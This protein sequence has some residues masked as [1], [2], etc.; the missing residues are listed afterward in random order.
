MMLE[1]F[2]RS[3]SQSCTAF[4]KKKTDLLSVEYSNYIRKDVLNY[5]DQYP[6]R[7]SS[8]K[9]KKGSPNQRA[10]VSSA[11][12]IKRKVPSPPDYNAGVKTRERPQTSKS[13]LCR[14]GPI[15]KCGTKPC[16]EFI[17]SAA[18]L[19]LTLPKAKTPAV[20]PMVSAGTGRSSDFHQ[21]TAESS[22]KK[23]SLLESSVV[24]LGSGYSKE[25]E[26]HEVFTFENPIGTQ[27]NTI[28]LSDV[29]TNFGPVSY[30]NAPACIL[31]INTYSIIKEYVPPWK[32]YKVSNKYKRFLSKCCS[33]IITLSQS[34]ANKYF[35]I[36]LLGVL[37]TPIVR[38]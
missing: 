17:T 25:S 26:S 28:G 35:K 23:D 19:K 10:R 13:P 21:S 14:L 4:H 20:S 6:M 38:S 37:D 30:E 32:I 1:N 3:S 15:C 11:E 9:P 5:L 22:I 24:S 18:G 16:A 12:V 8:Q 2:N 33:K 31:S 7:K 36:S 27:D 29:L 34:E